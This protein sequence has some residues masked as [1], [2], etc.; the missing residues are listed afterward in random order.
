MRTIPLLTTL[1]FLLCGTSLLFADESW[2]PATEP[3][4]AIT[5]SGEEIELAHRWALAAFS[6]EQVSRDSGQIQ[7]DVLRQ[8]HSS[9]QLGK[10]CMCTP[11]KLADRKFEHGLGTHSY[12]EIVVT[13]PKPAKEFQAI[14]GV[15]NNS[16]TAAVRGSAR[17]AI[18]VDGKELRKTEILKGNSPPL[19]FRVALPQGTRQFTL[20]VDDAGDGPDFDQVDWADAK[21]V[22]DDST[23]AYLDETKISFL[24]N[25]YP[26]SFVYN[27]KSSR[28]LLPQ[29][30]FQHG[31]R[32][33]KDRTVHEFNW[34]DPDTKL[35]AS[36]VVT[37][38]KNSPGV[39]W[40]LYFRNGSDKD[41]PT[42]ENVQA[43]DLRFQ[44][45]YQ[46]LPVRLH[47]LVGDTCSETA[48]LPN[49]KTVEI[50]KPLTVAP[51]GGRSSN[52]AFP[53]WNLQ[54]EDRGILTAIGWSGQ[55]S[56]KFERTENG[57]TKMS[58]G[59]EKLHTILHPGEKIR[60]P[61]I[62]ILPWSGDR[63]DAHV[64]FRRLLMFHY[65]PQ[66]DGRPLQLPLAG[67]CFD[68]YFAPGNRPDWATIGTQLKFV[69]VLKKFGCDTYW[70][71]AAW[72]EKSFP[73][74]VGNW[75]PNKG[76]PDGLKPLGDKVHREDMKFVLWFEPERV[77]PDT[78][79]ANEHP[80]FVFGGKNGGL[81]KL[82]DPTARRFLTDLLFALIEDYGVDV[83]RNDFNIDPLDYW[84]ANDE[85][86]R[87]GIT[88]IRYVEG[89]YAM[90]DEFLA[91][92]PGL[93]IDNC[94]SG[95]RRIDL[96]TISRSVTLWRSDTSCW[97]GNEDWDQVQASGLSQYIPLTTA[98]AW[99]P[100][101]Y[102]IRSAA[103]GGAILQFDFLGND[104]DTDMARQAIEEI[105]ANRK[106]WYGDF[107]P[108]LD[109]QI[110]DNHCAAYQLHRSDLDAGMVLLF[111][112]AKSPYST[113]EL[114]LRG[115]DPDARYKV[116]TIDEQRNVTEKTV[117]GAE[118]A[119][120]FDVKIPE[121]RSSVLIRYEKKV[122]NM[123]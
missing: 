82:N 70:F 47:S 118:L 14:V 42:L 8:D 84:R 117:P 96:E 92:K 121:K 114:E 115:I 59:M 2:I 75:F 119:Q 36:A 122:L 26:F 37:L 69:D 18:E 19:E 103:T 51:Q 63:T 24:T 49:M 60:S 66:Q 56:A 13:L 15:D 71:D 57:P 88:E 110:G 20:K 3:I 27:G 102:T 74:G 46:R 1:L 123:K 7:L 32:P 107:Y 55:W 109:A 45:G 111:R 89:H 95:G 31:T 105:K 116:T 4:D 29:W 58:C 97:A 108:I 81:Y 87:Q 44:S 90:W 48:W 12:S 61:R 86:N 50:G 78:Q 30:K 80:E 104:L 93:W 73:N 106:Y 79:I 100:T 16:D 101:A 28:E 38:F 94:A 54:W 33:E 43:V 35:T 52:G 72:F 113:L 120:P 23:T 6:G 9:L 21:V 34:T 99:N 77:A 17:F 85:E 76:F 91:R 68:R 83:Y 25:D 40:V 112:R 64:R 10:S 11:I 41:T 62:M 22:Y 67:Q 5:A 65:I 98:C 53:F 39:D